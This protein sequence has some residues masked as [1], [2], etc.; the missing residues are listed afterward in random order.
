MTETNAIVTVVDFIRSRYSEVAGTK[1]ERALLVLEKRL[2]VLRGRAERN[3]KARGNKAKVP[4]AVL[5]RFE[6]Q[7]PGFI[8]GLLLLCSLAGAQPLPPVTTISPDTNRYYL[9]ALTWDN[10]TNAQ[11]YVVGTFSNSFL[12]QV[13]YTFTNWTVVSNLPLAL[14]AFEFRAYSMGVAGNSDYSD[15][16]P[17]WWATLFTSNDLTNWF[18]APAVEFDPRTNACAFLRLSNWTYR[19]NMHRQ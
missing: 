6:S 1:T 8:A 16:A 9:D 10:V 14:D 19:P 13:T 5:A 4:K 3:R 17:L 15:K 12:V 7:I 18:K 2:G 11:Q